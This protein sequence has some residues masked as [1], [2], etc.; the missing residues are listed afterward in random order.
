MSNN[1]F[2]TNLHKELRNHGLWA[3]LEL[4]CGG[5]KLFIC[6]SKP[7][8]FISASKGFNSIDDIETALSD[9]GFLAGKLEELRKDEL[10]KKAMRTLLDNGY[11]VTEPQMDLVSA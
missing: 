2:L 10:C 3:K 11:D 8:S 4:G 7:N 6:E 1:D 9:I 5:A